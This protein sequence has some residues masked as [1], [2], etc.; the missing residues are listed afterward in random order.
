MARKLP[1]P[2]L[3]HDSFLQ[4]T[5]QLGD[6]DIHANRAE[7]WRERWLGCADMQRD[8]NYILSIVDLGGCSYQLNFQG[9]EGAKYH[10]VTS[11][12]VA[13]GM[14]SWTPVVGG[15]NTPGTGGTWSATV[16]GAAPVYYRGVAETLTLPE[17]CLGDRQA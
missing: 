17:S 1:R 14:G 15:T 7:E 13:T 5:R 4:A 2:P 12:D 11:S 3:A 16:S 10:V 6:A 9:T 8:G